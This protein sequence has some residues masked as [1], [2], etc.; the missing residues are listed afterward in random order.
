[1]RGNDWRRRGCF[2]AAASQGIAASA[3][4]ME[5][6]VEDAA[7]LRVGFYCGRGARMVHCWTRDHSVGKRKIMV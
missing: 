6:V 3:V 2:S 7:L 1:M 4:A 5:K